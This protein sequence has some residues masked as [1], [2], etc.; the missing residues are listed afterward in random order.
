MNDLLEDLLADLTAEGDQLCAAVVA[1]STTA[2]GP[3]PTPAAGWTVATQVAHLLWT[4]EV[5]ASPPAPT[6]R[7]GGVGRDRAGRDRRPDGFV[8]TGALEVAAAAAAGAARPLG[9][10]PRRAG[11]GAAR[12]PRGPEDA[13]V[14]AADVGRRRW[15]P[16]GS[17]RPGRTRSTSTTALGVRRPTPTDRIRHVAHLGVRT[18]D[19]AFGAPRARGAGRGVPGRAGR[20]RGRDWTW[21]PE[22]A[23]QTVRRVGATT[24]ACWSPSASTATTPTWSPTARTPS[25]GSHRPGLRRPAA[26][27]GGTPRSEPPCASATAPASTA[28]ASRRCAR[29]SRAERLDVL[30]GDYLA[31]LTMLILGKDTMKDPSL[32]YARTFVRQLE[33]CLGLALER[34]VKIVS[35]AGG[36][37]PAGLADRLRE[38]AKG[39]GLDPASRTSRATTCAPLGSRRRRARPPT[40]TS[41]ASASPPRSPGRRR[42][43][44]RSRHRRVAG[45][46]AGGRPLRLDADGVRRAGRRRRR[47]ARHRVRRPGH[48]RQLLRLPASAAARRAGRWASR[49]PRSPP[50]GRASSPSTTAPAVRSRSTPSPR[51]WS[52]RSRRPATS[53]PTSPPSSTPSRSPR[54]ATTGS[55]SPACAARLRP[56]G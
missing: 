7:Q 25:S 49:S 36:L 3:R 47:R 12:L 29:C 45:R 20:A 15:R 39:L 35:N 8:D 44:H 23:A 31:E 42:R 22:D 13:V 17:W 27:R 30:T 53:T 10:G 26:A 43:R 48:R 1:A 50:T 9:R 56:S 5:A 14:R 46:R 4:D 21:G 28:T 16:R 2:A 32:G 24:S 11:R 18:R 33:D 38:V 52:T 6:P 51:S 54:R 34:G 40:P 37:N 55:R 19:F 41:A